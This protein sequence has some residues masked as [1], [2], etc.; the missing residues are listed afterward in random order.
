MRGRPVEA[1]QYEG[2]DFDKTDKLTGEL[3]QKS[4]EPLDPEKVRQT[5]RRLFQTGRYRTIDVR[6]RR[7]ARV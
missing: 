4:G 2:V 1:I 5:T 6:W 3:T 7:P